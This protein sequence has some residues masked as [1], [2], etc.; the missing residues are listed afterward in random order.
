MVVVRYGGTKGRKYNTKS[1]RFFE[2]LGLGFVTCVAQCAATHVFF[3]ITENGSRGRLVSI[4]K[5]K[6]VLGS[7][8]SLSGLL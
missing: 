5:E 8:R 6:M 7:D 2:K 4:R 3:S 1:D